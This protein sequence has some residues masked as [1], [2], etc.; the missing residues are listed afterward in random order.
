MIVVV[1]THIVLNAC[2]VIL[3]LMRSRFSL[4]GN[5]WASVAQVV[6]ADT[7]DVL[8][9]STAKSDIEVLEILKRDGRANL[10]M[11]IGPIDEF[12]KIGVRHAG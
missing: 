3:F 6:T 7:E 5:T 10:R 8:D 2:I 12:G 11:S 4:L 1:L 9:S